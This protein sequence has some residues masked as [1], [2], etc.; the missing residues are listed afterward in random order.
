LGRK[1]A[2]GFHIRDAEANGYPFR[3]F[4][5]RQSG[6]VKVMEADV[7]SEI[8]FSTM[9]YHIICTKCPYF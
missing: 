9:A 5:T 4:T 7:S 1:L 2:A 8:Q 3:V 6:G